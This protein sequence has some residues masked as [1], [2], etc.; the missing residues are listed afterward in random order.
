MLETLNNWIIS[1]NDWIWT[2]L[3]IILLILIGLYFTFKSRFVQF[4]YFGEMFRLLGQGVSNGKGK[5]SVSSFQAFCIATA[6]RVGT[7]NLAGVATAVALG[8]SGAV[9][10]M[11]VLA[12]IGSASAFV[13]STLAQI[14]KEKGENGFGYDSL[15]FSPEKGC[16]F[17]ELETVEKKKISHRAKA[18]AVLK[19]KLTA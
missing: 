3:L 4:R 8:G 18:L 6:S 11:W 1:A 13:E 16:T 7:G 14:Y 9:F 19:S 15:F 12:L 2:Y 17:A 10:W 5:N